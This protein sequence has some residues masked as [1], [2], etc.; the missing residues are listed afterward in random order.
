MARKTEK[1]RENMGNAHCQTRNMAG[2][3]MN[4]E[5][6]TQ[7]LCDLEYGKKQ[8][9]TWKMKNAHCRTWSMLRKLKIIKMRKTHCST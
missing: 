1:K 3:Q 5:N 4:V 9:K 2:K 6:V 8:S 7:T